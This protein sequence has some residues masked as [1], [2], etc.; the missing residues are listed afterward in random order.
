MSIQQQSLSLDSI[1]HDIYT[2]YFLRSKKKKDN[3][4]TEDEQSKV[5]LQKF[6]LIRKKNVS[7]RKILRADFIQR[8][9]VLNDQIFLGTG[10]CIS[11]EGILKFYYSIKHFSFGFNYYQN[12][13]IK[14]LK[15]EQLIEINLSILQKKQL[16]PIDEAIKYVSK[17]NSLQN[18][19]C[20]KA[21]IQLRSY[22][23]YVQSILGSIQITKQLIKEKDEE[24][25]RFVEFC[26]KQISEYSKKSENQIFQFTIGRLNYELGDIQI[27][28]T[29]FSQSF[30]NLIGIDFSNLCNL[31]LRQKEIDLMLNKEDIMKYSIEGLHLR[32]LKQLE[33]EYQ[34]YIQTFDGFPIKVSIKK[35]QILPCN[36]I[37]KNQTCLI[38]E[39][40]FEIS[41]LDVD[42][43]DLENLINYREKI[44]NN[45]KM[46]F[47]QFI[48]KELSI[49]LEDVE[50]S[51]HSELFMEKYYKD[52]LMYLNSL[53]NQ[54]KN[55]KANIDK[56]KMCKFKQIYPSDETK[57]SEIINSIF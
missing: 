16:T 42:L 4:F 27:V 21:L 55:I 26:M 53:K 22:N 54:Y 8:E 45:D 11:K 25:E 56:S 2:R 36:E 14:Y 46:S 17:I 5:S 51:V 10:I 48:N 15:E 57:K 18:K 28:K 33:M 49:I 23:K 47:D 38:Q 43:K 52:N 19:E 32:I 34:C 20:K 37:V 44:M 29:G 39:Y 30:L 12:T 13:Q 1:N 35:K 7:K 6:R 31:L 24:M 40:I 50:Y 3:K 9:V 41:E